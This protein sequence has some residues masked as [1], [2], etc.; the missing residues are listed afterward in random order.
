MPGRI[1]IVTPAS[2]ERWTNAEVV[3]G[4]EEDLGDGERGAGGLLREERVDVL[5]RMPRPRVSVRERRDR[6]VDLGAALDADRSR[7]PRDGRL[8]V[9]R[10]LGLHP[11]DEL[12]Q[13][14][15]AL[16]IA[17]E[18]LALGGAGR[19]VAPQREEARDAGIQELADERVRAGVGVPDTGEVGERRAPRSRAG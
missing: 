2:R 5:T 19:R 16:E 3:V 9:R 14:G 8:G 6:D 7:D 13:L 1:G 10:A 11:V 4:V 12:D 18:E 17:E 15:R